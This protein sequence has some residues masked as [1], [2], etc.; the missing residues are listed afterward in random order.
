[1]KRLS[2]KILPTYQKEWKEDVK[3]WRFRKKVRFVNTQ[4]KKVDTTTKW[5]WTIKEYEEEVLM[6]KY[7]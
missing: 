4:G 1:M 3:E 7:K 2:R 6:I 5:H